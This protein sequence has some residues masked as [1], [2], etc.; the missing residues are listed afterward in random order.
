MDMLNAHKI[1][2]WHKTSHWYANIP[3][4]SSWPIGIHSEW[5]NTENNR[6]YQVHRDV[7]PEEKI[8]VQ[9]MHACGQGYKDP[10]SHTYMHMC[11]HGYTIP[12]Q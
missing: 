11:T 5:Y 12:E 9:C 3:P 10:A 4:Q 1:S 8:C 2:H 6:R 7:N